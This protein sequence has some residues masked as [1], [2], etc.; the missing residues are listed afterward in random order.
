MRLKD[1]SAFGLLGLVWGFSFLWIKVAVQEVGPLTLVGF[2]LL[3]GFAGLAIVVA[4]RRPA[5]PRHVRTWLTLAILGTTN[6]FIPFWLIS[7]GEQFIDSAVA[8]ILNGTMPLFTVV[9]AHLALSDDRITPSRLVGLLTGFLGVVVLMSRGLEPE[10]FRGS[11]LGQGAVLLAAMS[12]AFSAVYARRNLR[13]V[14]PLLQASVPVAFA[15]SLAWLTAVALESPLVLP[16]LPLTWFA[17]AWLGLL[18]SCLAYLLYFH[19]LHS[20]GPTRAS[21]VTYVFPVVGVF[22]GVI[23]LKERVDWHLVVGAGLVATSIAVVN[24]RPRAVRAEAVG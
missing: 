20:L 7:W 13:Q 2:R 10:G 18:G 23:F 3:F 8:S 17:L 19:L 1:W 12:Y 6:A 21:M 24:R 4:A 22:L 11:V 15:G 5:W 14:D 16:R 9:I